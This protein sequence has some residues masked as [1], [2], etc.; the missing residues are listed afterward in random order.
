MRYNCKSLFL[1]L[2]KKFSAA[3]T[4]YNPG[5]AQTLKRRSIWIFPACFFVT[6]LLL[7]IGR[8]IITGVHSDIKW[9]VFVCGWAIICWAVPLII[10]RGR[11]FPR[12]P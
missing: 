3:P 10:V 2:N 12:Q 4:C 5:M 8:L 1:A 11:Y 7:E 9:I 6:Y